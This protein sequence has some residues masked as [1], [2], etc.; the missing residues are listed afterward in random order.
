MCFLK[1]K[2]KE[3]KLQ[4]WLDNLQERFA[5]NEKEAGGL[6]AATR[7]CFAHNLGETDFKKVVVRYLSRIGK[8]VT[9]DDIDTSSVFVYRAGSRRYEKWSWQENAFGLLAYVLTIL[10]FRIDIII[11]P[12]AQNEVALHQLCAVIFV[13]VV[14]A[15]LDFFARANP[16]M[17]ILF[18]AVN[19]FM[20]GL[21][22][23]MYLLFH[24]CKL[25][26]F[27]QGK[28]WLLGM[29]VVAMGYVILGITF[30]GYRLHEYKK[31]VKKP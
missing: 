2:P 27:C 21:S 30:T 8:V 11:S 4:Q 5:L 31:Y 9:A 7:T 17:T 14:W 18:T 22:M 26:F 15:V 13:L 29:K 19:R 6:Y 28:G 1:R 24:F 12:C 3:D 25:M 20:P 23:F 10:F 16:K